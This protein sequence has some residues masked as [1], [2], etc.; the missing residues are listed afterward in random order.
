MSPRRLLVLLL[1]CASTTA[2]TFPRPGVGTA[3]PESVAPAAPPDPRESNAWFAAGRQAV[4]RSARFVAGERPARNLILFVG[5]GMGIA[6][7]TAARILEGQRRGES[8]EGNLLAFETLPHV[9]LSRTYNTDAQVSDSASTITAIVSGVK[10]QTGVLG[11][12]ERI[13]RGDHTSV[14]AARV[15][16]ILEEAEARG[17]AT[18]VVTTTSVTHATPAGCYAHVPFRFWE[19]DS[20]ISD[21]AREAGF[22]DIARQLVELSAGDGLEVA[23]GGG[24]RH[25]KP[26]GEADPEDGRKPGA[27]L[28]GRDL[29]REWVDGRPGSAYVWSRAQLEAIDP[30]ATTRLLGLFEPEDMH[31]ETDRANDVAGEPSLAEMTATAIDLLARDEDGFFLL[32]EGG[33]IDHGHHAGNAERALTDTVAF[34]DAVRVALEKTDPGET[35]VVVTADHSHTLTI[36][37]YPVRGNPI[38]G[39]VTAVDWLRGGE[40]TLA[41]DALGLPYTTLSYANGP[42]YTGASRSQPEGAHHFRHRP[43]DL[44]PPFE[45]GFDGV[46]AGRPDLTEIETRDPAFLQEA[47]V[48]MAQET[49]AG[50]DVPVYAGGP[51]AGLFHGVVEQSY[52][53]HAMVEALGWTRGGRPTR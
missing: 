32:V 5:D 2:C 3:G 25:F 43:C 38:L 9:A 10:T 30:R 11:V 34:S 22:P 1:L 40:A 21:A 23:L 45:C 17:L 44:R 39:K 47:T 27:R 41:R 24:R 52:L 46:R 15:A 13:R 4:A 28:D 42:G 31:W 53:Y 7:V 29:T 49:H 51:R 37:G 48:P 36:S 14:D 12:D 33:R 50:E 26:G 6:T 8:G 18:G 16:T 19:N 20:R 35:L